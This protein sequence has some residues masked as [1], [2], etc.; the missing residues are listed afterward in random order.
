MQKLVAAVSKFA[1]QQSFEGNQ[2]I[3][4]VHPE[5]RLVVRRILEN[6]LPHV[7]V[8]SYNEISQG[9][10]LKSVGMVE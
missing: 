8:V 3:L 1:E 6:S 5:V 9:S 2:P 4:L 10:Q 7:I